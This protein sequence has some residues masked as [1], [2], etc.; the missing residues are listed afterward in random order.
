M[1]DSIFIGRQVNYNI[2]GTPSTYYTKFN[3]DCRLILPPFVRA[4]Y[5]STAAA[6]Y[7]GAA[8]AL[9]WRSLNTLVV[10]VNSE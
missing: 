2:L 6:L 8:A 10:P 7:I 1:T 5:R 9:P 3:I 4:R